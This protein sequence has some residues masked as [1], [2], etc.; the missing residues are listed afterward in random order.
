MWVFKTAA[1]KEGKPTSAIYG[2][3]VKNWLKKR[4]DTATAV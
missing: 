2:Q 1:V 3:R 4:R